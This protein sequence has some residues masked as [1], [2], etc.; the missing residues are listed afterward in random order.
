MKFLQWANGRSKVSKT[1]LRQQ[2]EPYNV[3]REGKK[4]RKRKS[5][6]KRK[7]KEREVG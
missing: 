2:K 7:G 4:I 5:K 6:R 1:V 3:K